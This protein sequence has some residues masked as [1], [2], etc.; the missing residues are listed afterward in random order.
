[1]NIVHVLVA[2]FALILSGG[3]LALAARRHAQMATLPA[4]LPMRNARYGGRRGGQQG[5]F[6]LIELLVVL[7]CLAA[8]A[9][10]VVGL[11]ALVIYVRAHS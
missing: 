2:L 9:C 10:V 1:M 7:F 5:G 11:I 8:L 3:L 6:T 4:A